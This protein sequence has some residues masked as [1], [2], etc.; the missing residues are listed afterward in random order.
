M[1][2]SLSFAMQRDYFQTK[3][4]FPATNR[5]VALV[6]NKLGTRVVGYRRRNTNAMPVRAS[7]HGN[8]SATWIAQ[9]ACQGS[10]ACTR[11]QSACVDRPDGGGV[12]KQARYR[13]NGWA[14]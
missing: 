11:Q 5:S 6:L 3:R 8:N 7:R 4:S 10:R 13:S 12:G 2:C 9:S 14:H 1:S